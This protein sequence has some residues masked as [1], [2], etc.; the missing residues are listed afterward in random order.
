M[1]SIGRFVNSSGQRLLRHAD[2]FWP[3]SMALT[4][5]V[6]G[7]MAGLVILVSGAAWPYLLVATVLLAHAMVIAAYLLHEAAHNA[8]F[9]ANRH[10][11][12]LGEVMSWLCGA[13]YCTFSD[14]RRKHM[15][16]HIDN[17]DVVAFDYRAFLL[18]HPLLLRV[19]KAAEFVYIPAVELIMHAMQILSPFVYE[20]RRDRRGRVLRVGLI[21]GGLFLALLLW[22]PL[23]AALYVVA[24]LMMITML[25]FNDAFQHNF[26]LHTDL[27][28][29]PDKTLRGDRD[30]E[31]SHTFS[32]LVSTRI[33]LLNAVSLN[34]AYHNAHH[35]KPTQPWYSLPRLHDALFQDDRSQV[36][37]LRQQL[38]AYHRNRVA[39]VLSVETDEGY[40]ERMAQGS[41]LGAAGVSFLTPV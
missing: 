11:E 27:D 12:W 18:R 21:R 31:Q 9:S 26:T 35:E 1:L 33:P 4:Y 23:A 22:Q 14:I 19:V 5:A 36:L 6:G 30:Y 10:N 17:A 13:S 24:Y 40:R 38:Q 41:G 15:R 28:G 34:F 2:A 29:D 37:S 32:N 20:T 25:R 16:H 8:V 7:W 39:R 3:T